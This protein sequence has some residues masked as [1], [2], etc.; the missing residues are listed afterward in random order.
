MWLNKTLK[1]VAQS[2][3]DPKAIRLY[4]IFSSLHCKGNA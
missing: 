3:R 2:H 1:Y 4:N